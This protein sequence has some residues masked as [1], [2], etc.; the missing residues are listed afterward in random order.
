MP[1]ESPPPAPTLGAAESPTAATPSL[2]VAADGREDVRPAML[3]AAALAERLQ[4]PVRVLAALSAPDDAAE[5]DVAERARVQGVR[6]SL[7]RRVRESVG[8]GGVAWPVEAVVGGPSRGIAAVAAARH[9]ALVLVGAGWTDRSAR[10]RGAERALDVASSGATPVLA[11]G[12]EAD[13]AFRR[14]VVAV[15]FGIESVRAAELACRLLAPRGTLSLV[16]VKRPLQLGGAAGEAWDAQCTAQIAAL[17]RQLTVALREGGRA[18]VARDGHLIEGAG[19]MCAGRRDI[20]VGTVTL[21]GEPV[22]E[23]AAYAAA[24]GADLVATGRHAAPRRADEAP[25]GSAS[26]AIMRRVTAMLAEACVLVCPAA[27]DVRAMRPA[28]EPEAA[29]GALAHT[30]WRLALDGFWRRNAGRQSEVRV[31]DAQLGVQPVMRGYTLVGASYDPDAGH[32]ELT[33]GDP[34]DRAHHLTRAMADVCA[35]AVVSDADGRDH[36]LR[37]EHAGGRTV[38]TFLPGA[39]A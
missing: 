19:P 25:D 26:A 15:D 31:D 9:A 12:T 33:F 16:H 14:A 28:L 21:V 34:L 8:G 3:V 11:V 36:A 20:A 17:F 2:L 29:T 39:A 37:V 6:E 27:P 23:I 5:S 4:T 35:I 32:A 10:P 24:V 7:R 38:L 13:G 30:E 1:I 18:P 22:G